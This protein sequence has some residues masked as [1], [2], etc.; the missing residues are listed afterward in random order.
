MKQMEKAKSFAR[1]LLL[2]FLVFSGKHAR[3]KCTVVIFS[4]FY[5]PLFIWPL[6][7]LTPHPPTT[8]MLSFKEL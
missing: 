2:P 7:L 1:F 6:S 4:W 8:V 5:A 3:M